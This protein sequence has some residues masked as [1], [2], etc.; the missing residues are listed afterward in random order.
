[1]NKPTARSGH[2]LA[3]DSARGVT[4]LFGGY[5]GSSRLHDT[6]EW[7]GTDWTQRSPA[8]EPT[9]RTSHALAY[10]SARGVTVLFGGHNGSTY[11]DDTWEWDGTDWTQRF[12]ANKPVARSGHALAYDSAREQTVLFG[13]YGDFMDLGDTWDYGLLLP[14]P[15]LA[16]IDN[17]DGNGDYLVAWGTVVGALTYT[18][19]EAGDPDFSS[20][21]VRYEG[22]QTQFQVTLQPSG[23]WYYRVRASSADGESDWSDSQAVV[24]L[25]WEAVCLY[26]PLVVRNH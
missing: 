6:W 11:L 19:Q 1:V 16:P 14:A 3:Y 15:T 26:L 25:P 21:V 7:D 9:S 20:P 18:L 24:V 2:A 5:D 8:I 4:V 12:P 10:D 13:G 23:T 22:T 17:P